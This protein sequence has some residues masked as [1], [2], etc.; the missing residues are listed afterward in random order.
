MAAHH[1]TGPG[2]LASGVDFSSNS[3]SPRIKKLHCP[4]ERR[5]AI[6]VCDM[7]EWGGREGSHP[8]DAIIG[9][10]GAGAEPLLRRAVFIEKMP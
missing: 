10:W 4:D 5:I 1:E 8:C 6:S 9:N 2:R 7:R 3:A